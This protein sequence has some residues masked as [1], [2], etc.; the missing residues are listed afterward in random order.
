MDR[1]SPPASPDKNRGERID[2]EVV[3]LE[4]LT[5]IGSDNDHTEEDESDEYD[6]EMVNRSKKRKR[7]SLSPMTSPGCIVAALEGKA[8]TLTIQLIDW[9]GSASG[10]LLLG[11]DGRNFTWWIEAESEASLP[12][13]KY[14]CNKKAVIRVNK[15]KVMKGRVI[16]IQKF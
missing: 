10:V 15:F 16:R 8:T 6:Y 9:T 14:A 5:M 4:E 11:S 3:S 2:F 7:L 1:V 13:L 12:D